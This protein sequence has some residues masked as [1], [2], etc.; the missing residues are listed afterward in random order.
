MQ[1]VLTLRKSASKKELLHPFLMASD[2]EP[3]PNDHE[4]ELQLALALSLSEAEAAAG[5]PRGIVEEAHAG[6]VTPPPAPV[7]TIGPVQRATSG[8]SEAR[9][10]GASAKGS[11]MR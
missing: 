8:I 1:A 2:A 7:R 5:P 6:Q 4:D 11:R 9:Q 10:V 3:L